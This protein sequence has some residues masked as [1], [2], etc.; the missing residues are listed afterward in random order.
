MGLSVVRQPFHKNGPFE[1]YSLYLYLEYRYL[2]IFEIKLR[3][4]GRA[5]TSVKND[6]SAV[7]NLNLP[8]V[9]SFGI[10]PEM[11]REVMKY[12]P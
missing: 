12:P 2:L 5:M 4:D 3:P 8:H 9:T 6:F 11:Q 1:S 10:C 7:D